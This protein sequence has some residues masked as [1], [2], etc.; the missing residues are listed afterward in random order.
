MTAAQVPVHERSE[1]NDRAGTPSLAWPI[2]AVLGI[3]AF[4]ALTAALA[5]GT[6]FPFDRPLLDFAKAWSGP[7]IIWDVASQSANFPLIILGVGFVAWLIWQHRYREAVLAIAVLVTVTAGSEGVKELTARQRPAGNG[8]G[9]PGVVYSYPSGHIL[10]C[11]TILGM[12]T[13]RVW[14]TTSHRR[15]AILLVMLVIAEVVFVGIARVALQEHYPTDLLGGLFGGI[16]ALSLY[17]WFTRPGGWADRPPLPS[18][19]P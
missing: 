1:A 10:E 17:A 2:L 6:V 9:I 8:D 5:A 4:I 19:A 15:L 3:V 12:I 14:R 11:F 13:L 16:A 18:R 7:R